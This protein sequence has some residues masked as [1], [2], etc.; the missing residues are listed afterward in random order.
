MPV[1]YKGRASQI[2][3]A[4]YSP[5]IFRHRNW[6]PNRL[7]RGSFILV[8]HVC[9]DGNLIA[10][11]KTTPDHNLALSAPEIYRRHVDV[12]EP[13]V[14]VPFG[15]PTKEPLSL[16]ALRRLEDALYYL[17]AQ[18]DRRLEELIDGTEVLFIGKFDKHIDESALRS[19]LRQRPVPRAERP[20]VDTR[21]L[22]T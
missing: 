14:P 5:T 6:R 2:N 22:A 15:V 20:V 8:P 11:I 12:I 3:R 18:T 1:V 13:C 17:R 9:R 19:G 10:T 16:D 7:A 4:G 21:R